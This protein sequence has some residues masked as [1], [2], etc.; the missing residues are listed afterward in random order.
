V[1]RRSD[2]PYWWKGRK[3]KDSAT[4]QATRQQQP[5]DTP[6]DSADPPTAPLTWAQRLKRVFEIDITLCPLCG[7]LLRV[8]A[9]TTDLDLIRKILDHINSR[10]PPRLPP[11]RAESHQTPTDLFAER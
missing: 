4:A 10:A 7:G 6:T 11:R 5:A 3:S 9:D 2:R 1:H 8:I